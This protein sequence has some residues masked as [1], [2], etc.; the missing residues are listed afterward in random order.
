MFSCSNNFTYLFMEFLFAAA[1]VGMCVCAYVFVYFS[2]FN[3][4]VF[5]FFLSFKALKGEALEL[6]L[7]TQC[8]LIFELTYSKVNAVLL[9][10]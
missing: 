7:N 2:V 1:A 4:L 5:V 9:M 3:D 10:L 6:F 8:M